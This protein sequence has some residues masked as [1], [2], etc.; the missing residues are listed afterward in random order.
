M[1]Y[2]LKRFF[3]ACPFIL[4]GGS[5]FPNLGLPLFAEVFSSS[6]VDELYQD[7][8]EDAK[9]SDLPTNPMELMQIFRRSSAM[10]DATE[11]SDAIDQALKNFYKTA[12]KSSIEN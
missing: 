4:L 7:L 3:I 5:I 8:G 12:E 11:P 10:E 9:G 1:K 6:Q 2:F